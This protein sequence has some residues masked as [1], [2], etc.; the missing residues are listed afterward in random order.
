MPDLA[1]FESFV[2]DR[3]SR[4]KL[5]GLS[6]ALVE[7]DRVTYARGFGCRDVEKGLPATPRTLFGIG[8]VTKSFT[9]AAL[10]VLAEEGRL[11]LDDP[12]E[13][14]LPLEVRPM[15]EPIR[16][17]HLMSHTSGIPALGYAEALI[18]HAQG[19][20]DP[21]LA[22][23]DVADLLAFL[24]DAGDWVHDPPGRRWFYLNEGYALLGEVVARV[25]G[26]PYADF[27]TRRIL[28]PLGMDRTI[29]DAERFANDA[30]AAVPYVG[31]E[32]G[33]H[34]PGRYLFGRILADGGLIS[35]AED[36]ARYVAMYLAEGRAPGGGR[37]LS[38]ESVRQMREPIAPSPLEEP[39]P[40]DWLRGRPASHY[41]L[42]LS[43]APFFGRTL[44]G[45]SGSVGVAT[46]NMSFVPEAGLGAVVLANGS[47]YP[48]SNL[49]H[50]LLALR[51]GEDP[52]TLPAL[53]RERALLAWEGEYETYR[54]TMRARVRS[55]GDTL[56]VAL[57]HDK[58]E[59]AQPLMPLEVTPE[60]ARFA[61]PSLGRR[62]WVDFEEAG[63][64]RQFVLE[65]YLFRRTGPLA[66]PR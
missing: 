53:G 52:F 14:Y 21:Y 47:G 22:I 7:G 60:R 4:T 15:G 64:R 66:G 34:R 44:V 18:G 36:M 63:G 40:H 23:G 28:E 19:R 50:M 6:V 56:T 5:A 45:H 61:A 2:V 1:E 57:V 31:E 20:G 24:R 9:C 25:A 42:G 59:P 3:M 30:D 8:S 54:G 12:V 65:R 49:C 48:L 35:C 29:F 46:A 43:V 62:L 10:L 32:G 39:D 51:L 11:S 37:V 55:T 17:R 16:L 27:V 41:G 58:E 13:E 26:E 38:A 33:R